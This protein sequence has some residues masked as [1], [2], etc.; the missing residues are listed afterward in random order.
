MSAIQD[1]QDVHVYGVRRRTQVVAAAVVHQCDSLRM[2]PSRRWLN[3]DGRG[4]GRKARQSL[5]PETRLS[6]FPMNAIEANT[7]FLLLAVLAEIEQ[8]ADVPDDA[9][10]TG[11]RYLI[12]TSRDGV[13]FAP[14]FWVGRSLSPARRMAF[15]RAARRL[16]ARGLIRR[17]T[18]QLRDRV[19]CLCSN[20]PRTRPRRR[21]GRRQR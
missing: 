16:A 7:R 3:A 1:A 10:G 6:G 15:S 20:G 14:A 8:F 13:P 4:N 2:V 21:P 11:D 18:E 17:V 9:F 19:R 12:A 5:F